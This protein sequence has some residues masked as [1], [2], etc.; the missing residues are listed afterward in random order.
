MTLRPQYIMPCAMVALSFGSAAVY[1]AQ[2][3]W[4]RAGYWLAAAAITFFVTV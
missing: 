4:R 3:N 2:G 1:V